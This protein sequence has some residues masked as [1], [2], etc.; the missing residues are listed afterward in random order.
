[1]LRRNRRYGNS[2]LKSYSRYVSWACVRDSC[3]QLKHP[4]PPVTPGLSSPRLSSLS[5]PLLV[6]PLLSSHAP[7]RPS[8]LR[9]LRRLQRSYGPVERG[10]GAAAADAWLAHWGSCSMLLPG[11][12]LSSSNSVLVHLRDGSAFSHSYHPLISFLSKHFIKCT[13]IFYMTTNQKMTNLSVINLLWGNQKL[14]Q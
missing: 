9:L 14:F 11:R 7:E 4:L 6:S 10:A 8:W 13:S 12:D 1:M 2:R 5:C 3:L